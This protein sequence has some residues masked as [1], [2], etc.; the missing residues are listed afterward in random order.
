MKTIVTKIAFVTLFFALAGMTATG[1]ASAQSQRH[2]AASKY[3]PQFQSHSVSMP[4]GACCSR[5]DRASSPFAG[6][7][8]A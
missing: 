7:G 8:G 5:F 6:G 4:T 2:H 3:H 1:P